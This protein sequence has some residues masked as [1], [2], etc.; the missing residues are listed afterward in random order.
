MAQQWSRRLGL[1]P[2]AQKDDGWSAL[3]ARLTRA[4]AWQSEPAL[5]TGWWVL[6]WSE[7]GR[8]SQLRARLE[9]SQWVSLRD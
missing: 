7:G 4:G 9:R 3:S 6:Y 5:S 2:A 1:L 8:L